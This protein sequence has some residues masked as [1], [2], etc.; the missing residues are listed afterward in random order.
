MPAKP[1]ED[2]CL[3]AWV[4]RLSLTTT[5]TD[6]PRIQ[7]KNATALRLAIEQSE[8]RVKEAATETVR[9]A[10]LK[11][12]KDRAVRRMKGLMVPSDSDDEAAPPSTTTKTPPPPV[13]DEY[14]Y[15]D[16]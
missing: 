7:Q 9:V 1:D 10:K 15:V 16:N 12:E 8:R 5:E 11:R 13:T 6:T 14:G 4:Y 2:G 3:L